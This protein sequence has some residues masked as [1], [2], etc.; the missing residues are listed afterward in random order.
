[1][2]KGDEYLTND[3]RFFSGLVRPRFPFLGCPLTCPHYRFLVSVTIQLC[4]RWSL[5]S[6][7]RSSYRFVSIVELAIS[8]MLT[9]AA[10]RKRSSGTNRRGANRSGEFF[11]ESTRLCS[12]QRSFFVSNTTDSAIGRNV[13]FFR[14][15]PLQLSF[16]RSLFHTFQRV[17][18]GVTL[19]PAGM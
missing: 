11:L 18:M 12:R 4:R 15:F 14:Y 2:S 7:S 16:L 6:I 3:A 8:L 10:P 1:M 19:T 13:R 9:F 17:Q 5:M